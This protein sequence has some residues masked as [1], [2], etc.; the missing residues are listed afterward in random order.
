M[1]KEG[2]HVQIDSHLLNQSDE[3][4]SRLAMSAPGQNER[5]AQTGAMSTGRVFDRRQGLEI[6][7]RHTGKIM[8]YRIALAG[9]IATM[10]ENIYSDLKK[11][12]Q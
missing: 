10:A 1:L 5:N 6:D 12:R 11:N 3:V 4:I 2:F 7:T 8:V 9:V